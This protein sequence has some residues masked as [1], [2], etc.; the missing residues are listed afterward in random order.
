MQKAILFILVAAVIF[1]I[2]RLR[3]EQITYR[4]D[5]LGFRVYRP[6]NWQ[7]REDQ[8]VQV[9]G[10]EA[11]RVWIG[12][13]DEAEFTVTVSALPEGETEQ[14]MTQQLLDK[15]TAPESEWKPIT[16][17][18]QPAI[19]RADPRSPTEFEKCTIQVAH[20]GR[21]Y[22]ITTDVHLDPSEHDPQK[23]LDLVT[24]MVERFRFLD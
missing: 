7:V 3:V 8:T 22:T 6:R 10:T 21:K 2:W 18:G 19:L 23:L 15:A 1:S 13:P 17:N 9:G 14:S 20:G 16:V 11:Q 5:E 12:R 24:R 4:N